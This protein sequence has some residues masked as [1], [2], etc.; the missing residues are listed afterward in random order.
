MVLGF[1]VT[2]FCF[3]ALFDTRRL[4]LFSRVTNEAMAS[5][6]LPANRYGELVGLVSSDRMLCDLSS[7][8]QGH[9]AGLG[10]P[11]AAPG[12]A[13]R[14][15]LL[16][17]DAFVYEVGIE[18]EKTD[19]WRLLLRKRDFSNALKLCDGGNKYL[20]I[21]NHAEAL[22]RDRDFQKAA[23]FFSQLPSS[24]KSFESIVLMYLAELRALN[25]GGTSG[26]ATATASA[27]VADAGSSSSGR[28]R[29][30]SGGLAGQGS[31]FPDV[32][33]GRQPRFSGDSSANAAEDAILLALLEFLRLKLLALHKEKT[34]T[35]IPKVILCVYALEL[36]L[37]LMFG[38]PG[39]VSFTPP[40]RQPGDAG[41]VAN[42]QPATTFQTAKGLL[43]FFLNQASRLDCAAT[44]YQLLMS[45][46]CTEEFLFFAFLLRDFETVAGHHVARRQFL[47]V[48]L[49]LEKIIALGTD[50]SNEPGAAGNQQ[51]VGG[52]QRSMQGGRAER[53]A[54]QILNRYASVLF[55][56]C[57]AEVVGF[58]RRPEFAQAEPLSLGLLASYTRHGQPASFSGSWQR[59]AASSL[60]ARE[61]SPS[62]HRVEAIRYL[63][64]ALRKTATAVP[65]P[66]TSGASI[67]ASS[68]RREQVK[69]LFVFYASDTDDRALVR[70]L[71]REEV[72]Q[73]LDLCFALRIC[74]E[75]GKQCSRP[76]LTTLYAMVGNH[77]EAVRVALESGDLELA[78]QQAVKP[79]EKSEQRRLFL[80]IV[81]HE[82]KKFK[83]KGAN[84][85]SSA[86][87]I[88]S[89]TTPEAAENE[90]LLSFQALLA[91]HSHLISI[92]DL[93]PYVPEQLVVGAF[94]DDIANYLEQCERSI[95]ELRQEM[96]EHRRAA[97]LLKEDLKTV[98]NRSIELRVDAVCAFCGESILKRKFV[99]YLCTHAFHVDCCE[100]MGL[101]IDEDCPICGYQMIDAMQR[102]FVDLNREQEEA[103]SWRI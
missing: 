67:N 74:Q 96:R 60:G 14:Q 35:K 63:E 17:C 2:D 52:D 53:E 55:Q 54:V 99:T 84:A 7:H 20:V 42:N 32:P 79:K 27:L 37:K 40:P 4:V 82:G 36:C 25:S 72:P 57:P 30:V 1:A 38:A 51:S 58:L 87:K 103:D 22:F 68:L 64:Y 66:S 71:D 41:Q 69:L 31:G 81:E 49:L 65:A 92:R 77:D 97:Q 91:S 10:T 19:V 101:K 34:E 6:A 13:P 86:P 80:R 39:G 85:V 56:A 46:D 47:E 88:D 8:A 29:A 93:L 75:N 43:I 33:F 23:I 89:S 45:Y 83:Q 61:L 12:N 102:P 62:V 24:V 18:N 48:L 90:A 3:L 95:E 98:S 44:V 5:E 94:K 78:K 59:D 16:V 28:P 76:A 15:I 70:F 21:E 100:A 26:K 9:L 73:Q 11:P 50:A